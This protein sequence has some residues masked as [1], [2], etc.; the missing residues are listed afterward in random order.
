MGAVDGMLLHVSTLAAGNITP[1]QPSPFKGEGFSQVPAHSLKPFSRRTQFRSHNCHI[2]IISIRASAPRAGAGLSLEELA[3]P[4]LDLIKQ[5]EQ[6]VRDRRGRFARGRS[7]NPAGR[8]LLAP[9][10]GPWSR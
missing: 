3:M 7:G 4:D 1:S 5:G 6:G 2:R 8:V 9:L 10:A